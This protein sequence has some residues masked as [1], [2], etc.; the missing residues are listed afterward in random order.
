M[1]LYSADSLPARLPRLATRYNDPARLLRTRRGRCGEW[2]NCFALVANALGF[3]CRWVLDVTDHV[4]CEVW[5]PEQRRWAH[6]PAVA[7][8]APAAACA[9]AP[10]PATGH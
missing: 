4:W 2:A 6:R 1:L 10:Q 9:H 8:C 3:C 7:A 5:L